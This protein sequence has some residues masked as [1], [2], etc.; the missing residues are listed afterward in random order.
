[1]TGGGAEGRSRTK[2][3]YMYAYFRQIW[4]KEGVLSCTAF[5]RQNF[6]R[7]R[8]MTPKEVRIQNSTY[9]FHSITSKSYYP[10]FYRN[11]W[12]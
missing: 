12:R 3:V 4:A 9:T 2:Q 8:H 1:L 5:L 10:H 7:V 11:D 6:I